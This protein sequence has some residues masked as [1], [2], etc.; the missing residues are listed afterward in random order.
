M[1]D[2]LGV[3]LYVEMEVQ[4]NFSESRKGTESARELGTALQSA[5]LAQ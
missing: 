4:I 1:E 5:L 2:D 3:L